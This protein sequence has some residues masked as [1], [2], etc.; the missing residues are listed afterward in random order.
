[1]QT[2]QMILSRVLSSNLG[3]SNLPD[4]LYKHKQAWKRES[5][6]IHIEGGEIQK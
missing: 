5:L 6:Q 3:H 4:H 1:M 2:T